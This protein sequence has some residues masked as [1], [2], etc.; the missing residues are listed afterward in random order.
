MMPFVDRFLI[1]ALSLFLFLIKKDII[2]I[3]VPSENYQ[4][5]DISWSMKMDFI[6]VLQGIALMPGVSRFTLTL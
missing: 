6:R 5:T 1:T 3:L 4:G 2:Q